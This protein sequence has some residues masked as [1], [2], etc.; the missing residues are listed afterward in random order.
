MI[1]S[2]KS[3]GERIME[4]MTVEEVKAGLKKVL[5]EELLALVSDIDDGLLLRFVGGQE[6]MLKIEQ[7]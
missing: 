2:N 4:Q 7:G 1:L 3:Q 6:F 5:R